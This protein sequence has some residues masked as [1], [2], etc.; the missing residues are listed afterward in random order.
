M[1]V[2]AVVVAF[3]LTA[4]GASNSWFVC[5]GYMGFICASIFERFTASTLRVPASF[6]WKIRG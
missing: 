4:L 1:S 6:N 3:R 2:C 5:L